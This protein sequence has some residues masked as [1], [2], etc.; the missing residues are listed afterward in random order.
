MANLIYY[1]HENN[2]ETATTE[3]KAVGWYKFTA[4]QTADYLANLNLLPFWNGTSYEL[5]EHVPPIFDL[6]NFKI[7]KLSDMSN[8]ALMIKEQKYP[9]YKYQNAMSSLNMISRDE[10]P[11]YSQSESETIIQEFDNKFKAFRDEYYRLKGLIDIAQ[12]VEEIDSIC[13]TNQFDTI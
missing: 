13:F 11:M 8:L 10:I 12:S 7:M 1:F 6:D 3:I 5:I 2:I 4:K 9:S